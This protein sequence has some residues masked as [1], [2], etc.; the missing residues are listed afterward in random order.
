VLISAVEKVLA[1][2]IMKELGYELQT[3]DENLATAEILRD[4]ET[5]NRCALQKR[6]LR[7][8][9]LFRGEEK[10]NIKFI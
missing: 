7:S 2:N 10:R 6:F 3:E 5:E 4:L 9:M 8:T 1:E